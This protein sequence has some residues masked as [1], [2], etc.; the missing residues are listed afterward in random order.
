L[1]DLKLPKRNGL[2]VLTQIEADPRRKVS[3]VVLETS[4]PGRARWSPRV[5]PVGLDGARRDVEAQAE[6]GDVVDRRRR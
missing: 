1:L 2:E 4:W 3:P 6:L 5:L